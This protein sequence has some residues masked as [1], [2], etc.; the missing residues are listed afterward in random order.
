M[1]KK[2]MQKQQ[3]TSSIDA[4]ERLLVGGLLAVVGGYLD[5][6][7]YTCHGGVFANA[8]TGNMV[9]LAVNVF[10]ADV[11]SPLNYIAPILAFAF[12]VLLSEYLHR[13]RRFFGVLLWRQVVL[14]IE[15]LVVFVIGFLPM[16][17]PSQVINVAIS[18]VAAMQMNS[19]R[20]VLNLPYA[21]TVA[22]GNLR[23]MME[24][25][26]KVVFDHDKQ[27]RVHVF[28]YGGIIFMFIIG[29][30]FGFLASRTLQNKAIFLTIPIFISIL[31]I[32]RD[33]K[34]YEGASEL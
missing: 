13:R 26:A 23:S 25:V 1:M 16:T 4:H 29:A 33:Y 2:I 22:T 24:N 27:A 9:L 5:A 10:G 28:H 21:T 17:F 30:I 19:F 12:G 3:S 20:K 14:V 32:I 18:L 11:K 8:Q 15:M 7:T 31:V 6:F 34:K